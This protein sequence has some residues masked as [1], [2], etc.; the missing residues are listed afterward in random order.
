ML[1]FR[2]PPIPKEV[3][4]AGPEHARGTQRSSPPDGVDHGVPRAASARLLHPRSSPAQLALDQHLSRDSRSTCSSSAIVGAAAVSRGVPQRRVPPMQRSASLHLIPCDF[5]HA[6]TSDAAC[7]SAKARC[8]SRAMP[9]GRLQL[10]SKDT[11]DHAE[12]RRYHLV[13][14]QVHIRTPRCLCIRCDQ[15]IP[16]S[17]PNVRP[18]SIRSRVGLDG[19]LGT[20]PCQMNATNFKHSSCCTEFSPKDGA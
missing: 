20:N 10:S 6:A 4:H 5:G 3:P 13:A 11:V 17:S 8:V 1:G 9:E 18:P 2:M 12:R 15:W 14:V 7:C 16:V 19:L